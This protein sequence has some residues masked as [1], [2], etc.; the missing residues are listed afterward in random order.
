LILAY[1]RQQWGGPEATLEGEFVLPVTC[2]LQLESSALEAFEELRQGGDFKLQI[3]STILMVDRGLVATGEAAQPQDVSPV[4]P[5]VD[6]L[7][8]SRD[9]WGK[10]LQAWGRGLGIPLIVPLVATTPDAQQAEIVGRLRDA[11][12]KADGADYSGSIASSRKALELLRNLSAVDQP[13]PRQSKERTVDQRIRA[14][15]DSLHSLA[16]A[17]SH[18]DEPVKDFVP[19]RADAVG[20]AGATAAL[21]QEM[22]ARL[23]SS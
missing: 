3:E 7:T 9:M 16:S 23:R 21:A 4:L 14:V 22:F 19:R 10:A 17:S 15:V 6:C 5:H 1:P 11:W 20:L 12:A 2:P 8:V 18:A 13:L